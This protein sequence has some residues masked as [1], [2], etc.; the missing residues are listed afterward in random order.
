[1]VTDL[2]GAYSFKSATLEEKTAINEMLL[3]NDVILYIIEGVT[4]PIAIQN[5]I[6]LLKRGKKVLVAINMVKELEKRGGKIN[7]LTL[8]KLLCSNIVYGEFD[9]KIGIQKLKNAIS[10]FKTNSTPNLSDLKVN[11]ERLIAKY[12]Q[13]PDFYRWTKRTKPSYLGEL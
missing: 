8:Q 13:K 11:R 1:M 9:S 7:Y 10:N 5:V 4:L 12:N 2:P 3:A 6:E